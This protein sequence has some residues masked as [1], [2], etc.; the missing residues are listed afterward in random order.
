LHQDID[1]LTL[2]KDELIK[3][4]GTF[5][6]KY[7]SQLN[8]LIK[9]ILL[10]KYRQFKLKFTTIDE[11]YTDL[12]IEFKDK[13]KIYISLNRTK[14]NILKKL[15]NAGL[16]EYKILFEELTSAQTKVQY[17]KAELLDLKQ[18][19][20]NINV[21]KYQKEFE[22]HQ[23]E[24]VDFCST[25][26]E[27][28]EEEIEQED[29]KSLYKKASKQCH[30]DMVSVVQSK[31]AQK[32]FQEL[33]DAYMKKDIEKI[34]DIYAHLNANNPYLITNNSQDLATL[35]RKKKALVADIQNLK[36]KNTF[37]YAL[38]ID[39]TDKYFEEEKKKLQKQINSLK[40]EEITDEDYIISRIYKWANYHKLDYQTLPRNLKQLKNLEY[41]NLRNK[42]II[43]LLSE[44]SFLKKL[45]KINLSTNSIA[46]LPESIGE[47]RD[48]EHIDISHNQIEKLPETIVNLKNLTYFNL[49]SNLFNAI[50]RVI[51]Q[52]MAI[53]TLDLSGNQITN[54]SKVMYSLKNL[55]E[56]YF[57]ENK[58]KQLPKN[59]AHL[60]KLKIL[61]L[62]A[63]DI[64]N[65]SKELYQLKNL[66]V[67]S[68]WGNDLKFIP[69]GISK[70][71]NL[72][73]LNLGSNLLEMLPTNIIQLQNLNN[74]NITMNNNLSLT[75]QQQIWQQEINGNII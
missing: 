40:D 50:P 34:K 69:T 53:K 21:K 39:N 75:P 71:R 16:S 70:L 23:K 3:I 38:D 14:D 62:G 17:M 74:I 47:L 15:K 66:K 49:S 12:E 51:G 42:K 24:Y 73:E 35:Q 7:Y 56:L 8:P 64:R 46:K 31:A 54:F 4:I 48:L 60:K 59:I 63:N 27:K 18:L 57:N 43:Y 61:E 33:N 13:R 10:Y 41:L 19:I 55:E 1:T 28:N 37:S 45:K 25:Y 5:E 30:P 26:T 44:V 68:L 2:Q 58:L 52:L 20:K 32:T 67:I 65:I 36:T 72:K 11:C 9:T 6:K 29:I 22:K